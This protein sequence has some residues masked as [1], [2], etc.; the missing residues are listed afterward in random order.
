MKY[1]RN[2]VVEWG[3][4]H[5]DFTPWNTCIVND[6]LFVFD[7][8]MR[9]LS[10]LKGLD[11]WHFFV[12]TKQFKEKCDMLQIAKDYIGLPE[13]EKDKHLFICY[14]LDSI[15]LYLLRGAEADLNVASKRTELLEI[16]CELK[17]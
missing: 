5:R 4:C 17:Q 11:C 13:C 10:H 2:K 14:L 12:Q 1:Y 15:S 6:D 3:V 9:C 16:I 7:L 8:N